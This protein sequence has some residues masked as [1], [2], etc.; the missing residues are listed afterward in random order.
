M[1]NGN[2]V[3][4]PMENFMKIYTHQISNLFKN[5]QTQTMWKCKAVFGSLP[6]RRRL[7]SC[8]VET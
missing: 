8:N 1:G 5:L 7:T 6:S 3:I 4:M 2:I